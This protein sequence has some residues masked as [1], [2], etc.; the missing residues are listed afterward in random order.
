M[1]YLIIFIFLQ[2]MARLT[3]ENTVGELAAESDL[4]VSV[5]CNLDPASMDI[6]ITR[7][8]HGAPSASPV[9]FDRKDLERFFERQ[10]YKKSIYVEL[11]F[12]TL[13]DDEK[14]KYLSSLGDYFVSRGYQRV[15]IVRNSM[16]GSTLLKDIRSHQKTSEK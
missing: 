14:E 10:K 13:T 3:A 1:K 8:L 15:V 2:T 5:N 4:I 16:V 6:G 9:Y 11:I 12:F 7:E